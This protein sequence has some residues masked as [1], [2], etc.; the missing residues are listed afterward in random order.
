MNIWKSLFGDESTKFIKSAKLVVDTVNALEAE[1][2]ALSD[3]D[4]PA[5]TAQLRERVANGESLDS[6]LPRAFALV[7]E[8]ARRT[9]GE[10]PYDVQIIGALALHRGNLAEMRTGEGKTLVAT[11]PAYLNALTGKGVH[12]VTVNDYLARRDA[13]NMGQIYAFLGMTV[14]I[15]NDQYQSYQYDP[16]HQEL[17]AQR[18]AVAEYKVVYEFLRPVSKG[19]AYQCD[20]VYGTNSQFGFDYLRDNTVHHPSMLGQRGH[21]YAIVDEVDSILIDEA[22][23]PLILS[24]ASSDAG[25]MYARFAQLSRMMVADI[26]YTVDEK[27]HAV[28]ITQA[29]IDKA[30]KFLDIKNLYTLETMMYAHHLENAVRAQALYIRDRDYVIRDGEVIIVDQ[31]TGRM[32]EGRRWSDGLHQAV[33]AKE[34]VAVKQESHTMA[35]ITYQNYFKQ[36]EK[37]SGM[38]GTGATSSEEFRTVYGLDVIVVPTHKPIARKDLSDLIYINQDAKF[39]AIAKKVK[40]L[41]ELGQPVLIGTVSIEKNELLSAYLRQ[42]GIAHQMLNAKN[43]ENEG[44]IIA[45][46]GIRGAVTVATNM[47][48][49]GVD[50]KLGGPNATAEEANAIRE[51]GGLY[52]IGTERHEARR[53]DNQLRGRS[54]RQGDPGTTQFYVSLDDDLMRIFG[55]ER[56]QSMMTVMNFPADEAIQNSF[57]SSNLEKAQDRI[58]GFH[59]DSRKHTLSYDDILSKH[60]TAIYKRRRAILMREPAAVA[61][62]YDQLIAL[63]EAAA[64]ALPKKRAELGTEIFDALMVESAL[65]TMDRLWMEH[66]EIMDQSRRSVGLR[67]YGQREPL[68]EYAREAIRLYR[69]F[70]T[71]F[72]VDV[73]YFLSNIDPSTVTQQVMVQEPEVVEVVQQPNP[74]ISMREREEGDTVEITKDGE[75]RSV[76]RKKIDQWIA[77]GWTEVK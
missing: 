68:I 43:H 29:G 15:I 18:D 64:E 8:A 49:R 34:S 70:E 54:G 13:V 76:K 3:A 47:A 72:L 61:E 5:E 33:E 7:R 44:E 60:R 52:V 77:T 40:E 19:E 12:V 9:R 48:G 16:T 14:G 23:V 1:I 50:I 67:A 6:V 56:M 10:R 45:M 20:I 22:R 26:D 31:F 25:E 71:V 4:F 74:V 28:Q 75:T 39:R 62:L 36:Y 42:E 2:E 65:R 46:G 38:T 53:I 55:G 57:I 27:L 58:E 30:E 32:Q 66:L 24:A 73:S 37:L 69:E 21:Y 63:D 51:L 41:T 17:D 59:F 35:S 11:L